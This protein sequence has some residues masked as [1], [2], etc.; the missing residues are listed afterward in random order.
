MFSIWNRLR[1]VSA[2][3]P[4]QSIGGLIAL[5]RIRS[6]E[7]GSI[8]YSIRNYQINTKEGSWIPV[9]IAEYRS[10]D[11]STIYQEF[12]DEREKKYHDKAQALY[13]K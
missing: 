3:T 7:I 2:L 13:K 12:C 9:F 1:R 8:Y 4:E 6:A 5:L 11:S 10:A